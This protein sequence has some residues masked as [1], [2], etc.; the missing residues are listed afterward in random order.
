MAVTVPI[1]CKKC[2]VIDRFNE[3]PEV[4]VFQRKDGIDIYLTNWGENAYCGRCDS[5]ISD[6]NL[7]SFVVSMRL[8]KHPTLRMI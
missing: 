8:D 1:V 2:G 7:P 4:E 5:R 6:F 3:N